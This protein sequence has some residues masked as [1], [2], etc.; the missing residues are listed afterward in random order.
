M[1]G[2][3]LAILSVI[4]LVGMLAAANLRRDP[5][6]HELD[7]RIM[8]S[9]AR[10]VTIEPPTRGPVVQTVTA[11]GAVELVGGV[12]IY[13]NPL[14]GALAISLLIALVFLVQG[15]LQ[16][17]LALRIREQAGWYWFAVSGLVSLAASAVLVGKLP[18]TAHYPPGTVAGIALVIAGVAYMAIALTV[19]RG[20]R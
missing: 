15:I 19:R 5:S 6:G 4:V 1:R 14:K 12:L 10:E 18:Y 9:P 2:T 20:Q 3:L 16:I 17:A 7:W 11:P 8:K 13:F